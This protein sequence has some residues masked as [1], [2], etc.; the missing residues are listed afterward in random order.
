MADGQNDQAMA[1]EA[2]A[3]AKNFDHERYTKYAKKTENPRLL[4]GVMVA[5]LGYDGSVATRGEERWRIW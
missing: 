2:L 5:M 1:V 4:R 3:T